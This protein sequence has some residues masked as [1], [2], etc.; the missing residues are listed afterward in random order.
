MG[1]A[2]SFLRVQHGFSPC[3]SFVARATDNFSSS[4]LVFP[5][6]SA[7]IGYSRAVEH[8]VEGKLFDELSP[9]IGRSFEFFD[10]V[11]AVPLVVKN[12][13]NK[14]T[15]SAES[16]RMENVQA[17]V[18]VVLS[19]ELVKPLTAPFHSLLHLGIY[20]EFQ[21]F[22]LR[23]PRTCRVRASRTKVHFVASEGC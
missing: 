1:Q 18:K 10:V 6:L 13:E 4:E 11:L 7:L 8:L 9:S 17:Y 5:G 19:D 21:L 20:D 15:E 23:K 3:L 14:N 2:Y 12:L 22:R 16:R